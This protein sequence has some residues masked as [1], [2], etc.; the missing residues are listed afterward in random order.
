MD[1]RGR[2][3]T[4]TTQRLSVKPHVLTAPSPN[5]DL[6]I[7]ISATTHVIST[8]IVVE[9]FEPRLQGPTTCLLHQ[10]STLGL[11]NLVFT[12]TKGLVRNPAHLPETAP[13]FPR[14][15]HHSHL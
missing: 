12:D 11:Q 14:A 1:G 5:E 4:N 9:R 15:Q 8:A 2:Q 13:L 3:G 10:R 6:L 7:Y